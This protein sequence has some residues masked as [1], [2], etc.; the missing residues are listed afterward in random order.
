GSIRSSTTSRVAELSKRATASL[1]V[2][3][4][5]T[6]KPS[7]A[8]SSRY[9]SRKAASSS[10][11]SR[12]S[13]TRPLYQ[14]GQLCASWQA[15]VLDVAVPLHRREGHISLSWQPPGYTHQSANTPEQQGSAMGRHAPPGMAVQ[16]ACAL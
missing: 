10:T 3:A 6:S 13:A 2:P 12:V 16:S 7:P 9:T 4:V 5:A 11:R 14:S 8:S 1:A 15:A